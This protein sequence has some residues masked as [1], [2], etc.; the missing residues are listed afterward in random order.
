METLEQTL[1]AQIT[2]WLPRLGFALALFVAFWVL[3]RLTARAIRKGASH[4]GQEASC[5]S[6]VLPRSH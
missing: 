2:P 4:L 1:L 6:P 3:A 5:C